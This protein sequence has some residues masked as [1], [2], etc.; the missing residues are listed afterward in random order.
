MEN[1]GGTMVP[2]GLGGRWPGK[3]AGG[4]VSGA[5]ANARIESRTNQVSK[6]S[7]PNRDEVC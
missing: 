1:P 7:G 6:R 2:V 4:E 5:C 3:G